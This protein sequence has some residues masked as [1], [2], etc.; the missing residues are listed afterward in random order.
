[1]HILL[2]L[3]TILIPRYEKNRT[4]SYILWIKLSLI[5]QTLTNMFTIIVS[6]R[7]SNNHT[8]AEVRL[9]INIYYKFNYVE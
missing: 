9:M 2:N 7:S 8:I 6:F 1:M 3:D 4:N 5:L